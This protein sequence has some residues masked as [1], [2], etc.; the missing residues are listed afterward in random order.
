[1]L[2]KI[3]FL[4]LCAALSWAAKPMEPITNYNVVLVHGADNKWGGFDCR[5]A[6]IKAPYDVVESDKDGYFARIGGFKNP[7]YPN[8]EPSSAAGML[9]ELGPWLRDNIF[10]HDSLSVYLQRPFTNPANSP[11]NNA[12][13]LGDR[14]WIGRNNC[15]VRRSLIEEA[16]EVRARGREN[17]SNLRSDINNRDKLPPS[18]NILIAHSLGG[19]ASREYVQGG[20]YNNDVD[21]IIALDSPHEGTGALNMLLELSDCMNHASHDYKIYLICNTNFLWCRV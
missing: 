15:G 10:E 7:D 4:F 17:L 21:K 11:V 3:T 20:G 19:L 9:K 13:E 1:M 5:D 16:Q 8:K 12:R 2:K 18:R 6:E 14:K